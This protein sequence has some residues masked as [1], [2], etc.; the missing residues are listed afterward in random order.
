MEIPLEA[1]EELPLILA[2]LTFSLVT[3]SSVKT[4]FKTIQAS[5]EIK[6]KEEFLFF[7]LNPCFL[8]YQ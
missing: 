1:V 4:A 5:S 6:S 3:A 7:L 8:T 2:T